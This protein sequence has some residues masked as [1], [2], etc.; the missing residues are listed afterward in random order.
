MSN[1]RAWFY[2]LLFILVLLM[3]GYLRLTGVNWGEGYHQHP[4][5]LFLSGV[6]DNLRA[7]GCDIPL[8]AVD[9]CPADQRHWLGIR[10][11]FDTANSTL[12]PYNRG[13]S[14]FV[15]GNLPMT[16][17][18][19][20]MEITDKLANSKYLREIPAFADMKVEN[21]KYFARQ[22]SALADLLTIFLL[23]L[24]VSKL[25]GRRIGLFAATFSAF[26]V[27]QIQQSHFFTSD[28]FVN[29]FMFLAIYFA[30]GIIEY[31]EPEIE[32]LR[33]ELDGL[34]TGESQLTNSRHPKYELQITN[35]S[36]SPSLAQHRFWNRARHGDGIQDQCGGSGNHA[37]GCF[38]CPLSRQQKGIVQR[39]LENYRDLFGGGRICNNYFLPH[40]SAV[41]I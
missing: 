10:E 23:Y 36:F 25:Y 26:A 18:R 13:F 14:F 31:Q 4:D 38:H 22:F 32:T 20:A 19:Y 40:F 12:N 1:K 33:G 41:C 2:D 24:I 34:E 9:A 15:Y 11:Y 29:L 7:Q 17:V 39:S 30:V 27:M 37:A 21:S 3:A 5:E 35:C 16:L 28:L 6:L 8:T